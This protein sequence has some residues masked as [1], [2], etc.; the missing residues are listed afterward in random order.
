M[1]VDASRTPAFGPK[2][3]FASVRC[4]VRADRRMCP[5]GNRP[6]P[7]S[8]R[9]H[10]P[11]VRVAWPLASVQCVRRELLKERRVVARSCALGYCTRQAGRS[12]V[13][14]AAHTTERPSLRSRRV[15]ARCFENQGPGSRRAE[16]GGGDFW[17]GEER[18]R[19]VGARS[20]LR[21]HARRICPSAANEVRV[22]SYAARLVAEHHS[23]VGAQ[24]RPTQYEPLPG[25]ARRE[26]RAP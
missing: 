2:R 3:P 25:S 10:P 14:S 19:R 4:R 21:K 9:A 16:P 23:G 13:W 24:R 7:V 15:G 18:R 20:A 11:V 1:G 22:A 26:T 6:I 8:G 12:P 17:G 5:A